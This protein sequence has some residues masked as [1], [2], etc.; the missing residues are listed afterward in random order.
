MSAAARMRLRDIEAEQ[1][2]L[3]KRTIELYQ[4]EMALIHEIGMKPVSAM[5][6]AEND[7]YRLVK[8]LPPSRL[9]SKAQS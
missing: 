7:T 5:T 6:R 8:K 9:A 3:L 4:E 2:T 1:R